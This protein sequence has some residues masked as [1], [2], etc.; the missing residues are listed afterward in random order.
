VG[1]GVSVQ[2]ENYDR[3]KGAKFEGVN[4]KYEI[5]GEKDMMVIVREKKTES[6]FRKVLVQ[7]EEN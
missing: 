2:Q 7:R 1:T 5:L 4:K 3:S 6:D